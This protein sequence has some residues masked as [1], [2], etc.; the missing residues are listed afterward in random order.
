MKSN[1]QILNILF[2]TIMVLLFLPL[3]Q[4]QF[5][6]VKVNPLKGSIKKIERPRI[7]TSSWFSEQFQSNAEKYLNQNFGFRNWLVRLN[8][9]VKFS[10]FNIAQANGVIVGKEN[11]L[12]E[13]SYINAYYG[14]DFLGEATINDQLEKLSFIQNNLSTRNIDVILVFAP[15]KGSFYPEYIPDV[16]DTV[17]TI[18][19]Y[20]YYVKRAKELDINHIDFS[21][22]FINK[23]DTSKYCLY[24]KTGIH[25]SY[26][27]MNLATDSLVRYIEKLRGID[28]PDLLWDTII[29]KNKLTGVDNDIEKGM[30]LLWPISNFEMPYPKIRIDQKNKTKPRAIVI[31][32]SFYWQLHNSGYSKS[33]FDKGEFWFYNKKIYPPK[34]NDKPEVSELVLLEEIYT[35]D[36]IILMVTEPVLKRNFWGFVDN[37][38]A[39]I[40]AEQ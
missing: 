28:M 13:E 37:C 27:G 4:M 10:L 39:A 29:I 38:Y 35:N 17:R 33:L 6:V 14:N 21:R 11:Y 19:N 31:A 1:K 9:Q 23:K 8:N 25:W 5:S 18:T 20:E 36:V 32:D 2:A 24:P 7:S 26:Y 15:S 34:N 40:S 16:Y 22:W 3:V 30:N 12:F